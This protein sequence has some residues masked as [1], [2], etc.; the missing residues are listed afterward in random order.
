MLNG[1]VLKWLME[2]GSLHGNTLEFNSCRD[3]DGGGQDIA[4][5]SKGEGL[6]LHVE[7]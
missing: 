2:E 4:R 1:R 6:C 5:I 7:E 3:K